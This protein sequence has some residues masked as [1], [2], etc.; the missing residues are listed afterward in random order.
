MDYYYYHI[1]EKKWPKRIRLV[2]QKYGKNRG[3]WEPN[4]AR[5]CVC[6][7]PAHCLIASP[8]QRKVSIYRTLRKVTVV[9][10]HGVLD[11]AVTLEG[12][13]L[14]PTTFIKVGEIDVDLLI[15]ME[16]PGVGTVWGIPKQ[17]EALER[18]KVILNSRYGGKHEQRVAK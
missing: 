9:K 15:D 6:P 8:P 18:V 14:K 4:D 13:R 11:V 5:I 7:S 2:P 17:R 12:W 3:L 16:L 1:T 10:P